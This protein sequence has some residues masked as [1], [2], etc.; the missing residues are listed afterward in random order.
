M[1]VCGTGHATVTVPPAPAEV[2]VSFWAN[3]NEAGEGIERI[4]AVVLNVAPLPAITTTE[5]G[6]RP[7]GDVAVIVVRPPTRAADEIVPPTTPPTT[8][9]RL[10]NCPGVNP[11]AVV[12]V[13]VP[14]PGLSSLLTTTLTIPPPML[15]ALTP[16][17]WA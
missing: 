4:T 9:T 13:T 7:C 5:P 1:T 15:C 8:P 10:T 2:S 16:V 3:V 17:I 12:V 6:T 14:M 11:W